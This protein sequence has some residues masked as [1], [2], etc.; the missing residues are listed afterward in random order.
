LIHIDDD[1]AAAVCRAASE[2][3]IVE[4]I[5]VDPPKAYEIRI[6]IICTSLCHTDVTLWH[7]VYVRSPI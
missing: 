5:V 1:D 7:K 2:P 3:L 4:E 6:K